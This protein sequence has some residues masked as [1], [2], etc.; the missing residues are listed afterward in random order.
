MKQV[1][2]HLEL[3]AG[4][5]RDDLRR[6][7]SGNGTF[8]TEIAIVKHPQGRGDI[9]LRR[10]KEIKDMRGIIES[11]IA[12]MGDEVMLLSHQFPLKGEERRRRKRLSFLSQLK[13]MAEGSDLSSRPS[14]SLPNSPT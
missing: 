12:T 7:Q 4:K 14:F 3:K 11:G 10:M 9:G 2:N 1:L 13:S 6:R 5:D 8:L